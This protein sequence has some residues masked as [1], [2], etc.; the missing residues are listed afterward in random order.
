MTSELANRSGLRGR[1]RACAPESV[2]CSS[3]HRTT[4]S[5]S[6]RKQEVFGR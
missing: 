3:W 1:V 5:A 6:V 2:G 4:E